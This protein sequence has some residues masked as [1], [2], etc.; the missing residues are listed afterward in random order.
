M[1]R[2]FQCDTCVDGWKAVANSLLRTGASD[3]NVIVEVADPCH[4]DAAWLTRFNPSVVLAKGDQLRDVMNTIFPAKTFANSADRH[5]AYVRYAKADSRSRHGR[6]GTYF[7]R[8]ISFGQSKD[9]QLE[10]VI[11]A[12]N[13]WQNSPRAA[14]TF[15]LSSSEL[16]SLRPLG[17]PCWHFGE[18]LCPDRQSLDLVA[19]YRNHDY[20]NKALGNF[21]GLSR[22]LKFVARE[23]NRRPGRLVCHSVRAYFDAS[24]TAMTSLLNR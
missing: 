19:V 20:F 10:N 4:F 3:Q 14:L 9:N 2:L 11:R 13:N 23:A 12:L 18:F 8:L 7:G 5:A 17:A 21:L 22:L 1:A 6:W 15:H 16:D 24:R